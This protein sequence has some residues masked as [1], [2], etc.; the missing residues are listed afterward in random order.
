MP[1]APSATIPHDR[2]DG[3]AA[4]A[5]LRVLHAPAAGGG[6]PQGLALAERELGLDSRSL[7]YEASP[8]GYEAVCA[9]R[10]LRHLADAAAKAAV[11]TL[12]TDDDPQIRER[13]AG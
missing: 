10:S 3:P 6:H 11:E 12:K 8:F 9:Q 13:A 7:V 4:R 2:A 5:V 1:P